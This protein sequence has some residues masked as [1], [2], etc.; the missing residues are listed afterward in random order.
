MFALSSVALVCKHQN[1]RKHSSK[2]VMF[3]KQ[4]ALEDLLQGVQNQ[5]V[6]IKRPKS[7]N[8][9]YFGLRHGESEANI[10]GIISSD[11]VVGTLKHGLTA[12][13]V[14]QARRAAT[15][16]IE[17]VGRDHIN[18]LIFI[19]SNFTRARQTATEC[20]GALV[21]I[22]SFELAVGAEVNHETNPL[23]QYVRNLKPIIRNE[24]RERYFGNF[25][26]TVLINYNNVW[27][28]D[29]VSNPLISYDFTD[30]LIILSIH[31]TVS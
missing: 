11:P 3:A 31:I 15:A 2:L 14:I 8:N 26:A 17:K 1:A 30:T 12:S 20:I 19:S 6:D 29:A 9:R 10:Q 4:R 22:L 7:F 25:D 24:L 21:S 5:E 13:G 23:L 27:P 18:D 16:I 28:I